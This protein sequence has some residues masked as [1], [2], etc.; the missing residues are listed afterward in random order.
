MSRDLT[1]IDWNKSPDGLIP[2]IVQDADTA[3]VLM[4]AYMNR[5][6]LK[7]TL[8]TEL[9]TFFSRSKQRL[10]QKGESSKH[11]LQLTSIS[12]DCDGDALLVRAVPNG[13]TC[14]L[15][16]SSCFA[17]D[18]L[19]VETIGALS[20]T[21]R[22][23][24]ASSHKDS[25]TRRLLDGGIAACGAKVLEEAEEVVRAAEQ[26]GRERTVEEAAD[27]LYHL[28]VLLRSQ[29]IELGDVAA[30]LLRRQRR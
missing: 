25:Y 7:Q 28:L 3:Q 21:I 9:V 8:E 5:D 23:R 12:V 15:G 17:A 19:A 22:Q 13:P 24:A 11:T 20:R 18:E 1:S 10:W 26:E 16:T 30:E 27:V 14:H 2:A 4:V 29:G 6:A